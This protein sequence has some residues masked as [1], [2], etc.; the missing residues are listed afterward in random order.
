MKPI[1][2]DCFLQLNKLFPKKHHPFH[3]LKNGIHDLN[4]T[5]FE[6]A[7]TEQ[8]LKMYKDFYDFSELK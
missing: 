5:D 1:F 7:H 6:Y 2:I 8:L 3:D 4:Y